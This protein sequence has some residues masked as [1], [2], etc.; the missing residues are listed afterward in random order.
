MAALHHLRKKVRFL[1]RKL[2]DR[3]RKCSRVFE[4]SQEA[5]CLLR[6][7]VSRASQP[8]HLPGQIIEAG[9]PVLLIHLW[10][11]RLPPISPAGPD[12]AWAR[13]ILRRFRHSLCL[14]ADYLK[15][16]PR[17]DEI[18]AVGGVTILVTSGLHEGGRRFFQEMGFTILP[19]FS[20]LGRFGEFWENF[21]SWLI[22][23]TFN[24]GSLPQRSLFRLR[25]SEMWM[26]R[27]DFLR[28]FS[29]PRRGDESPG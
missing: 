1:I 28:R 24:P 13:L 18:R 27:E 11:E 7:Q 9:E 15:A 22:V 4:F 21:Y 17:L 25:R 5:G 8:L 10:N 3:I 16:N 19:Y 20:R 23:W 14:T 26:S 29:K 12:L 6:L 2:D